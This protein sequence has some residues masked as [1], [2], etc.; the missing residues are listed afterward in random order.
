MEQNRKAYNKIIHKWVEARHMAQVSALVVDFAAKIESKGKILDVGCGTG[1]PIATFLAEQGFQITGIDISENMLQ[2]AINRNISQASF[3]LCDFFDF[4]PTEKYHGIIAFDS[5]FHFPK[6]KQVEIYEKTAKW[7]H[8]DGYL[9]FTH[10]NK[11]SEIMGEMFGETFYYSCLDTHATHELL[12][13]AGFEITRSIEKYI[14]NNMDRDLV[15]VAKK[16]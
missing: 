15:I 16:L 12:L 10:G 13:K 9:L 3:H 8:K 11:E 5:F 4:E 6:N 14:E 7:L 2:E 1:Y